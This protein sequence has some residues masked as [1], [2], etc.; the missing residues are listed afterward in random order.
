MTSSYF[1]VFVWVA[2]AALGFSIY[3]QLI[4]PCI[5]RGLRYFQNTLTER[6]EA[7]VKREIKK[8]VYWAWGQY[9]SGTLSA[10]ALGSRIQPAWKGRSPFQKGIA[11][12]LEAI[13]ELERGK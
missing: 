9:G 11:I 10:N 8:G 13:L 3:D 6:R 5:F 2:S 4:K 7:A 12:A 1:D